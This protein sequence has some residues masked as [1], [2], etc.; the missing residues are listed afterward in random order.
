M[1]SANH[2]FRLTMTHL[3]FPIS[4]M[5]FTL[6]LLFTFQSMQILRDRD[7]LH[8]TKGSQEKAFED[9]QR[10]TA[11]LNALLLGTQQ[12][13]DQGDKNAKTIVDKLK[14]L[15]ITINTKNQQAAAPVAAAPVPAAME[16]TAPGPVK[17]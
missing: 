14:E 12:L 9:S 13:A 4:L 15:G 2:D 7:V 8:E 5:A 6:M 3:L 17:P 11:Q 16:K 1:P 10:L